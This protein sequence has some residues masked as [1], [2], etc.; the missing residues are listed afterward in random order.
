MTSFA[1]ILGVLAAGDRER[2]GRGEPALD[3][4]RRVRR[5]AVR[6]DDRH[7]LHS[8]LLPG[9]PRAGRAGEARHPARQRPSRAVAGVAE[10]R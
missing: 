7:L 6:D 2:R 3:R 1:F 8:A 5:D 10:A 9:D 4:H